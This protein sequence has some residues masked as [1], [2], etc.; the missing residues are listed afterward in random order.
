MELEDQIVSLELAK[1]LKELG[2]KQKSIF[3]WIEKRISVYMPYYKKYPKQ[4]IL[5][6]TEARTISQNSMKKYSAPTSTELA[7]MLPFDTSIVKLPFVGKMWGIVHIKSEHT[8]KG[9]KLA[10]ALAEMLIY[11]VENKLMEIIK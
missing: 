10:D 11:L 3:Y 8:E 1:K 9:E 6:H 7:E 2:V 5:L 4:F